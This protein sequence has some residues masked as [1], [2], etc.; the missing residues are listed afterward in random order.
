MDKDKLI[1]LVR[2]GVDI[3]TALATQGLNPTVEV[4]LAELAAAAAEAK[5]TLLRSWYKR[6]VEGDWEA[7]SE[8]LSYLKKHRVQTVRSL[9]K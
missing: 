4:P 1:D 6:S 5:A 9:D 7:A 3:D 2:H 8:L